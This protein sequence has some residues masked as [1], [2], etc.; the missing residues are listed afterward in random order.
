[1]WSSYN[2]ATYPKLRVSHS[3]ML[4]RLPGVPRYT[5]AI[6][7]FATKRQDKVDVLIWKQCYNLKLRIGG[8]HNRVIKSIFH[9]CSFK[10]SKLFAKLRDNIEVT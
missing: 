8:S 5:S 3:D 2:L 1:M 10:A 4:R 7:L 9:S 6:T